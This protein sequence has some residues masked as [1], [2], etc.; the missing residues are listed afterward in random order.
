MLRRLSM[1]MY[2]KQ[3]IADEL[4]IAVEKIYRVAAIA[5][6]RILFMNNLSSKAASEKRG[7][8]YPNI[9]A[10]KVGIAKLPIL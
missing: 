4:S 9:A 5:K 2:L 3:Q 8:V 7:R 1:L 6:V 10:K